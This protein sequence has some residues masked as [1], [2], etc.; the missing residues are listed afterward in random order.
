MLAWFSYETVEAWCDWAGL[1]RNQQNAGAGID[2]Y[3][4]VESTPLK[5]LPFLLL[6]FL[7]INNWSCRLNVTLHYSSR[8][9]GDFFSQTPR[10]TATTHISGVMNPHLIPVL[11]PCI[12]V[13]PD[14][15]SCWCSFTLKVIF[16]VCSQRA[17]YHTLVTQT[18]I[19]LLAA[20]SQRGCR[21]GATQTT[22]LF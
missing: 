19:W 13:Q 1:L 17:R 4:S 9:P 10:N 11:G 21:D 7:L 16:S 5:S 12:P 8:T 18:V 20:P 6:L 22:N 3:Y 2:S 15:D 14:R